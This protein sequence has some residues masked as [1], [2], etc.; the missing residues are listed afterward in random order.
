MGAL[1]VSGGTEL[2]MWEEREQKDQSQLVPGVGELGVR[3]PVSVNS[4]L[5]QRLLCCPW[6]ESMEWCRLE[7]PK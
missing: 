2:G 7:A 5:T 3:I 1:L 6:R 4:A